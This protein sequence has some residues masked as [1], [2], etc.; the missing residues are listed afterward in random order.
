MAVQLFSESVRIR[1]KLHGKNHRDVSFALYNVGLCH[2]NMGCYDEAIV[3]FEETLRIEKA[4]LG[5][6]HKDVG[7]T[8]FKLGEVHA[9]NRNLES[10]LECFQAALKTEREAEKDADPK[11]IARI[12]NEIGNA[13]LLRGETGLMMAAFVEAARAMRDAG[14]QHEESLALPDQLYGFSESC[15]SSAAAA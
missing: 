3:S 15:P 2:Y 10:A 11:T 12:L 13:H 7:L 14:L 6:T 4:V 8:L 9:A 5:A 1:V